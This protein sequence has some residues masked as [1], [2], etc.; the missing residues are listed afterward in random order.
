MSIGLGPSFATPSY[1]IQYNIMLNKNKK[2]Y[3]V[4]NTIRRIYVQMYEKNG[5]MK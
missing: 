1:N 5:L 3:F 4:T 2:L